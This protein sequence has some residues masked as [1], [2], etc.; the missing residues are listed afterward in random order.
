MN[1]NNNRMTNEKIKIKLKCIEMT[2]NVKTLKKKKRNPELDLDK[3]PRLDY[4]KA[5]WL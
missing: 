3:R 4:A 2:C 1:N 5:V